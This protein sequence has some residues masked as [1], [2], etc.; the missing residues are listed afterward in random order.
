MRYGNAELHNVVELLPAEGGGQWLL[1]IPQALRETLNEWANRNAAVPGGCEIRF[2]VPKDGKAK[3][4][5]ASDTED[6][7][8]PMAEVFRGCFRERAMIVGKE[9]TTIEV[10]PLGSAEIFERIAGEHHLAFDSHLVRILLPALHRVR[11]LGIEGDVQPPRPEQLPRRRYLAYGS[12]ITHG[13]TA[14][15]PSG[16]YAMQTAK[17]MQADLINLGFG[18]GAH[19]EEGMA[20]YIAGRDDWDFATLE[21]GINVGDSPA[22]KFAQAARRFLEIVVNAHPKKWIFCIDMFTFYGDLMADYQ[23]H[24]GF[25][26]VVRDVVAAIG[27]PRLVHVDGQAMLQEVPGLTCDLI[28]PADDG[29]YEMAWRLADVMGE[30][31]GW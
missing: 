11:L 15:R 27:A 5:L 28:H 29:M 6:A 2:N 20:Q 26:Q 24:V 9:P 31:M 12:S 23:G 30:R 16:T 14:T 7:A 8:P 10:G 3:V 17:W 1:R 19:L 13:S 22:E 18:G 4:T 21:L 25:R